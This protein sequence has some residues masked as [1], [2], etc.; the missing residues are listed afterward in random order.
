MSGPAS[1]WTR[2]ATWAQTPADRIAA[3]KDH[4]VRMKKI[5]ELIKKIRRLGFGRSSDVGASR[6]YRLEA[7][8]WLA[9]AAEK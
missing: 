8:H 1:S 2:T 5:E 9:Q 4:L 6:Y 7:E 3:L